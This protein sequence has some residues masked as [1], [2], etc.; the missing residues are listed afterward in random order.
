[1]KPIAKTANKKAISEEAEIAIL[2]GALDEFAA[3]GFAGATTRGIASRVELSHGLVRYYYETKENLWFAA[4]EYLFERIE[5][6]I[7]LTDSDR[8]KMAKGDVKAFRAWLRSYVRYCARHP[9]H[10]RIIYHESL[11]RSA[12]LESIV[13]RH[14]QPTHLAGLPTLKRLRDQ[15]VF[16]K[17]APLA[18]ILYIITGAA[19]NIFALAEECRLSLNYDPLT[20]AAIEAHAN[21]VADM[22][23]PLPKK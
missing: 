20:E 4:V 17:D 2:Q 11:T 23:C 7:G 3:H 6:E 16:P 22:I 15:G 14:T 1:M 13:E 9:E 21:A 18:S 8:D 10:A 5:A 19:Q 12:R